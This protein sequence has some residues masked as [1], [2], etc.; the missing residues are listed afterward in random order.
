MLKSFKTQGEVVHMKS[1]N[2]YVYVITF[3]LNS[4]FG[5][6]FDALKHPLVI[7]KW[8]NLYALFFFILFQGRHIENV[9]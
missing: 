5:A 7:N 8:L 6:C 9:I 1:S 3:F 2:L 4:N